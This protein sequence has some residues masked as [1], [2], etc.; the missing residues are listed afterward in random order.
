MLKAL[1]RLTNRWC[2]LVIDVKLFAIVFV[3]LNIRPHK[4]MI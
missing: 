4:S 3:S 2:L 1:L